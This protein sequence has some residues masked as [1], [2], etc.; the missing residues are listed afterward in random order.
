V[1]L[2]GISQNLLQD[3]FANDDSV[4]TPEAFRYSG[5]LSTTHYVKWGEG[6]QRGEVTI[7]SAMKPDFA[8]K[9]Q[10]VAVLT[11][12]G[13]TDPAPKSDFQNVVG[14]YGAFRHRITDP[15]EGGTVTTSITGAG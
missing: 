12:D 6:V 2:L 1:A 7:E 14:T 9:W 15:I 3:Q 11:F 5:C 13:S 8:G 10:T 4:S